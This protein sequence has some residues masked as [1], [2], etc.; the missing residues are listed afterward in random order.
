[1]TIDSPETIFCFVFA[2]NLW[3][4]SMIIKLLIQTFCYVITSSCLK[5]TDD[6]KTT[7][8]TRA[9]PVS[10]KTQPTQS[11]ILNLLSSLMFAPP[12]RP[13]EQSLVFSTSHHSARVTFVCAKPQ[14]GFLSTKKIILFYAYNDIKNSSFSCM[15]NFPFRF[16]S[17]RFYE[18]TFVVIKPSCTNNGSD[19]KQLTRGFVMMAF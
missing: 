6:R 14:T 15:I 13:T 10:S 2:G 9:G 4:Q 7:N 16:L 18:F 8:R 5:S 3:Q 12:P 1:M 19:R 17:F 11:L